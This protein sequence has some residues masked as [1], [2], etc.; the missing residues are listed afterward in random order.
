MSPRL[1]K[2]KRREIAEREATSR[3]VVI[4]PPE[5]PN[6]PPKESGFW[7][8]ANKLYIFL[9]LIVGVLAI[10]LFKWTCSDRNIS[11][12]EKNRSPQEKVNDEYDTGTLHPGALSPQPPQN[13]DPLE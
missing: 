3:I 10:I 5:L 1:G 13:Y 7:K 6:E 11:Q 9:G 4:P 2:K 8:G 12:Q